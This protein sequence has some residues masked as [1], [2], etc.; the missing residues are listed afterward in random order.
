MRN[1]ERD[2]RERRQRGAVE[3]ASRKSESAT[4]P[5]LARLRQRRTTATR[6][7]SSHRPGSAIPPTDAA[8][9]AAASVSTAGALAATEE[10]L[11][12]PRLR[13][14]RSQE[15]HRGERDEPEVGAV[16][17]PAG[18][19]EVPRHEGNPTAMATR[20]KL[21]LRMRLSESNCRGIP[22]EEPPTCTP[23]VVSDFSSDGGSIRSEIRPSACVSSLGMI[24]ILLESPWAI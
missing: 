24:H 4:A 5:M 22:A 8:P 7:T 12:P 14:V 15:D 13:G 20:T 23:Y 17:R 21:M 3:Q 9:P 16:Q 6:I 2:R 19:R 18:P 11:P 10:M 1:G